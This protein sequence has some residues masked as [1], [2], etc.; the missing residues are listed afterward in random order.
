MQMS[1]A[2]FP[3]SFLASRSSLNVS[4]LSISQENTLYQSQS[5]KTCYSPINN[6]PP[7]LIR[8]T[9]A[10]KDPRGTNNKNHPIVKDPQ[11]Q[12]NKTPRPDLGPPQAKKNWAFLADIRGETLQ[13][14][15]ILGVRNSQ[16][17]QKKNSK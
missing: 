12:N 3:S 7:P 5:E 14:R 16:K 8:T 1:I 4:C 10:V 13:K 17:S 2:D 15:T 9:W 11:T 6:K